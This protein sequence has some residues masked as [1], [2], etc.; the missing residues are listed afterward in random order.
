[1]QMECLNHPQGI[2]SEAWSVGIVREVSLWVTFADCLETYD[3]ENPLFQAFILVESY[4]YW[5]W[6]MVIT[7]LKL[8]T[9]AH[10]QKGWWL[11]PQLWPVGRREFQRCWA[12]GT[13]W[14]VAGSFKMLVPVL[15]KNGHLE[16]QCQ[17]SFKD[18][19][20]ASELKI[21]VIYKLNKVTIQ[22]YQLKSPLG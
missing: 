2:R 20:V 17:T 7:L 12:P 11:A 6:K 21:I 15:H 13:N 5:W 22:S 16:P 3:S 19:H 9:H 14:L 4:V 8:S 1:M 18:P 10:G